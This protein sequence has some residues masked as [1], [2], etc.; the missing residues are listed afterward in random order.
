M[1]DKVRVGI[2]GCG[3]GRFHA[4]GYAQLPDAEIVALAD[5]NPER[6]H[7]ITDEIPVPNLYTSYEELLKR[8]DIDA[9]S[10]ALPN[11]LHAPATLAA[12]EAGKHVLVEKPLAMTVEEGEEMVEAARRAGRKL[13]IAFNYRFR[14]DSQ[15]IKRQLDAGLLGDIYFTRAGWLRQSGIPGLGSWF[16]DKSRSGGGPL[17]D[18]GVHVLDLSMWLMG[19]PEP[20]AASGAT[21]AK[22]G[23]RGRGGWGHTR[24]EVGPG[25]FTVEDMATGYI[26]FANGATLS[27][28]VSWASFTSH[29]DAYYIHLFGTEG[30]AELNVVQYGFDDNVRLFGEEAG[31]YMEKHP[32]YFKGGGHDALVAEFVRCILEDEEPS[33]NGEDGLRVLRVID[34]LYRSAEAGHEV[35][36]Q[37]SR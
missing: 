14:G 35:T 29:P 22:F 32:N 11:F 10:I 12:L 9:V 30:G 8:D 37:P 6:F 28:E 23:P 2:I 31:T 15:T 17:I 5:V 24:F 13:M 36:I 19:S 4:R 16:T 20:V 18:L 3:V 33:P 1:T 7:R 34:A 21:Y 27:L 25:G 26:R